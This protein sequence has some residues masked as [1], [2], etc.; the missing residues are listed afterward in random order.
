MVASFV[1]TYMLGFIGDNAFGMDDFD[2][3]EDMGITI[4]VAGNKND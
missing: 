1:V 2:I 3:S 4:R